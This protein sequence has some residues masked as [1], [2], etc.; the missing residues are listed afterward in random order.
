MSMFPP[1]QQL[2]SGCP[3]Q[4]RTTQEAQRPSS[5]GIVEPIQQEIN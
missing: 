2:N 5:H 3:L 4:C 1:A